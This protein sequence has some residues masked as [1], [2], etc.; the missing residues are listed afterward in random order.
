M[1]A[2]FT[3]YSS[4]EFSVVLGFKPKIDWEMGIITPLPPPPKAAPKPISMHRYTGI[5]S[6]TM[7]T[8]K[9][10]SILNLPL[11]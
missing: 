11:Q 3:P 10:L 4:L 8:T 9:T 1:I 7:A 6:T 2:Y 5:F